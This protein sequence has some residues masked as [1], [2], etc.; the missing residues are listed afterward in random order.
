MMCGTPSSPARLPLRQ[1]SLIM[2]DIK[3]TKNL[4]WLYCRTT[5]CGTQR[6]R[7]DH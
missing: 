7:E 4:L 5:M 3:Q 1:Q 2:Q 6:N